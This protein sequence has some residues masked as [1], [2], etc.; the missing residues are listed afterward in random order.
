MNLRYKIE[1][2]VATSMLCIVLAR[3]LLRHVSVSDACCA[4]CWVPLV[5]VLCSNVA[6]QTSR[7]ANKKKR[8]GDND[9]DYDSENDEFY[10]RTIVSKK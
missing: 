4:M 2:R 5:C 10:D 9:D 3:V 8:G 7:A 6:R 1:I